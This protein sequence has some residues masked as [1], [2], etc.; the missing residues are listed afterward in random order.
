MNVTAG[1]AVIPPDSEVV[2]IPI[3]WGTTVFVTTSL[4][5]LL[6]VLLGSL[7]VLVFVFIGEIVVLPSTSLHAV[8]G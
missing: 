5:M 6:T 1:A 7:T 8:T 2:H 4:V 3:P